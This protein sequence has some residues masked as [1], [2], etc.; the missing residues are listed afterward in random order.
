MSGN[1]LTQADLAKL[2][3]YRDAADRYDYWSLLAGLGD[4]Y[5]QLA[6]HVVNGDSLDGFVANNYAASYA[7]S[8]S[9]LSDAGSTQAWW[10]IGVQLMRADFTARQTAFNNN[11]DPLNLPFKT[12]E[13]YHEAV[14][15][16]AGL[17]K[18]AW[19]PY[20]PLESYING[21]NWGGQMLRGNS[22]SMGIQLRA[23]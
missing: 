11:Q 9:A 14:L 2:E 8:G 21:G 7:P 19:T 6:L 23:H 12:I 15:G 13:N 18:Q 17:D 16:S 10:P 20:I 1:T 3:T 22:C 5:A 4:K